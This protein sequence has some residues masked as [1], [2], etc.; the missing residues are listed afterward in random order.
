MIACTY[1]VKETDGWKIVVLSSDTGRLLQSFA[2]PYPFNQVVRWTPDGVALNYLER[3]NGVY[4]IWQQRLDGT[5]PIQITNF[6]EDVIFSY[7]W[8]SEG[9]LVVSRGQKTRDIVLIRNFE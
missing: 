7:D 6:T 2:L 4:N 8:A 1:R 5:A 9:L 3:S